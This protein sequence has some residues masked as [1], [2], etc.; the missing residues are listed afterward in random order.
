MRCSGTFITFSIMLN[1]YL[2]YYFHFEMRIQCKGR[3]RMIWNP[4]YWSV[5]EGRVSCHTDWRRNTEENKHCP[6]PSGGSFSYILLSSNPLGSPGCTSSLPVLQI[7][8]LTLLFLR[9]GVLKCYS[10]SKRNFVCWHLSDKLQ[11]NEFKFK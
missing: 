3:W 7:C 4:K 6:L 5:L 9:H 10:F 11:F 2:Y 8:S 1:F